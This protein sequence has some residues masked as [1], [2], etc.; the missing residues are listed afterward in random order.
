MSL[1]IMIF[2]DEHLSAKLMRSLAA[3]LGHTVL[4]F[5]D[6]Q[7]AG[8][9]A[10]KQ[11]FDVAFVGMRTPQP[12]GL[13][14]ARRIR[15][16]ELNRETTIVMLSDTDDIESLRKAFGEGADF[17]LPKPL[18]TSRL[19]PILA[20]MDSPGWKGKRHAARLPLFTE[21]TCEWNDRHVALRSM[22]ISES[23]MLLQPSVDI[24]VGQEVA[25]EFE[26]PEVRASLHVR[27]RIVRKE[28]T[29]RIAIEFIGLA[30]EHQNAI[31]LYVVGHLKNSTR[32][33]D[34]DFGGHRMFQP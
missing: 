10:E 30:P 31:Q 26:I 34:L 23:G 29:E 13:E 1:K 5:D 32:T 22:N 16:S 19:R 11:R 18:G 8:Q 33:R 4:T 3:P 9:R 25:L 27:A 15:N 2:D 14:L 17:V 20:A 12:D 6:S 24:E 28:G 7:E 21:V